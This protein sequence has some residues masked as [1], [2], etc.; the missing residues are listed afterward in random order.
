V[1]RSPTESFQH[2]RKSVD[3]FSG[4]ADPDDD[5]R[6]DFH[7]LFWDYSRD[8]GTYV[9]GGIVGEYLLFNSNQLN[10]RAH[11]SATPI[12]PVSIGALYFHFDLAED[13]YFGTPVED[14]DFGDEIDLY[15]DR[16]VHDNLL[17]GAL[18]GVAWPGQA[19]KELLG[20]DPFYLL[21]VYAIVTF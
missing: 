21:L 12:E 1:S 16:T 6:K 17:V 11:L 13:N 4:D 5:T 19:A 2:S 10:T 3:H 20:D 9:Q 15:F 8:W 14:K 7:P 18:S